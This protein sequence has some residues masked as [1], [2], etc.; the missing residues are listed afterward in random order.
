MAAPQVTLERLDSLG[1]GPSLARLGA[2]ALWAVCSSIAQILMLLRI[3][4][5]G[6]T[7]TLTIS[8]Q[9]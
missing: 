9:V 4:C 6:I 7:P 5:L 8:A 1:L 3:G 2:V